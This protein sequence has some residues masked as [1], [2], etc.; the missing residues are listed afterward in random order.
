ML[1]KPNIYRILRE[2]RDDLR[3][4][5]DAYSKELD[6]DGPETRSQG[7]IEPD[8]PEDTNLGERGWKSMTIGEELSRSKVGQNRNLQEGMRSRSIKST[9]ST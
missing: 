9:K 1:R 2:V 5:R 4:L 6:I 3:R 8:N 7:S